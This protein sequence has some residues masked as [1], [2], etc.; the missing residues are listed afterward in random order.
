VPAGVPAGVPAAATA[1]LFDPGISVGALL[2]R[3]FARR[4]RPYAGDGVEG[5]GEAVAVRGTIVRFDQVKGYGFVCPVDGGEDL[6]VHVND[7]LDEKYLIR[8]GVLVEYTE[9]QGERGLKASSVRVTGGPKPVGAPG[10]IDVTDQAP[11][12]DVQRR[13]AVLP[14]GSDPGV[15]DDEFVDVL[16]GD[17]FAREVTE[18][19]LGVEPDLSG[20]QIRA[21][22]HRFT[23]MG[24]K[25]NWI[26]E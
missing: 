26:G 22:R 8:P 14:A 5:V 25:Y 9:E 6:F 15:P 11:R 10:S 3:L 13:A 20:S 24:R 19:L 21:V 18:M 4:R 23:A 16:S 17:S 12:G 2:V 1:R 7:L